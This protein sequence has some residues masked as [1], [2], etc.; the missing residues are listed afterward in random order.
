VI[1]NWGLT[2]LLVQHQSPAG[3]PFMALKS[4][5][6]LAISTRR[7]IEKYNQC[8]RLAKYAS[9]FQGR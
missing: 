9:R 5:V 1:D 7:V 8:L 3:S 4:F 6:E 2:I